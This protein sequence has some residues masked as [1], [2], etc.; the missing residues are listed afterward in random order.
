M[1]IPKTVKRGDM[2]RI[3]S[4]Q[5]IPYNATVLPPCESKNNGHWAC[6]THTEDFA[7]NMMKD[8]HIET[9]GKHLL[10]WM[11]HEHGPEEP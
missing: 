1:S 7:N 10:V 4:R 11:C 8:G 5:D 6:V 3:N 2:V 9:R